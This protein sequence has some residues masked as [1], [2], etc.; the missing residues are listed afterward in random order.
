[1]FKIIFLSL[2]ILFIVFGVYGQQINADSLYMREHFDK[3]EHFIT[4][5]DGIQLFTVV[6]VPKDQT[7]TPP[8]VT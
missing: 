8:T 3:S 1:M 2:V 7:L 4:M 5:R 6:Y